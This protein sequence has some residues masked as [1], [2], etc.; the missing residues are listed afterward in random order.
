MTCQM[1]AFLFLSF[2]FPEPLQFNKSQPVGT[3]TCFIYSPQ[4]GIARRKPLSMSK[5]IDGEKYSEKENTI[6]MSIR[7]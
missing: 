6:V 2:H 3:A 7:N 4:R 5:Y 1:C